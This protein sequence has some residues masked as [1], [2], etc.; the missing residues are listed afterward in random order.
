METL[1]TVVTNQILQKSVGQPAVCN[2]AG[3]FNQEK[4]LKE[5][6]AKTDQCL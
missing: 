3:N 4:L 6:K 1:A 2:K 5:E